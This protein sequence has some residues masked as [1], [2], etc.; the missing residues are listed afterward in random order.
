ME[1]LNIQ[2]FRQ[3]YAGTKPNVYYNPDNHTVAVFEEC[4]NDIWGYVLERA[5]ALK[6]A[7]FVMES[8][9]E[10]IIRDYLAGE[11]RNQEEKRVN[12]EDKPAL[13]FK[14]LFSP[15]E[16]TELIDELESK[17]TVA[18]LASIVK[19]IVEKLQG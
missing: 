7:G 3:K 18:R 13:E 14:P 1:Y 16:F 19:S 9:K 6:S 8:S 5:V 12:S 4:D 10:G 11:A 17:P 2:S 15:E